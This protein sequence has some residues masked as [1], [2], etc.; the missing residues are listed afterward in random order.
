MHSLVLK[1]I[2][3]SK[4]QSFFQL[5]IFISI[6]IFLV[7]LIFLKISIISS[8]TNVTLDSANPHDFHLQFS[9][10]NEKKVMDIL[11][12][13]G[14]LDS[15][16]ESYTS[17]IQNMTYFSI[18]NSETFAKICNNNQIS[19]FSSFQLSSEFNSL[20]KLIQV[21][22]S[23]VISCYNVK[24]VILPDY[25]LQFDHQFYLSS[26]IEKI[27]NF[28]IFF[29]TIRTN[30]SLVD[31]NKKVELSTER[32]ISFEQ[33]DN[34][35][36]ENSFN[37]DNSTLIISFSKAKDLFKT[38]II[39]NISSHVYKEYKADSSF[40]GY[41][42]YNKTLLQDI[43]DLQIIKNFITSFEE[44][45]VKTLSLTT[46]NLNTIS[47][48]DIELIKALN[49][50]NNFSAI[51]F[52][53]TLPIWL[54]AFFIIFIVQNQNN[55]PLF[56]SFGLLI[57]RGFTKTDFLNLTTLRFV[58]LD[59]V[60]TLLTLMF[61]IPSFAIIS[62]IRLK[63]DEILILLI[64]SFSLNVIIQIISNIYEISNLFPQF[65]DSSSIKI[66]SYK[67]SFTKIIVKL[68]TFT[69][70]IFLILITFLFVETN[71]YL[72]TIFWNIVFVIFPIFIIVCLSLLAL[73]ISKTLLKLPYKNQLAYRFFSK[74]Q[75][76][77]LKSLGF[78]NY[79][80]VMILLLIFSTL[81]FSMLF[82]LNH[83]ISIE[84]STLG[85]SYSISPIRIDDIEIP[86]IK[87]LDKKTVQISFFNLNFKNKNFEGFQIT[88]FFL[89][90]KYLEIFN[91][92]ANNYSNI[93]EI[94]SIDYKEILNKSGNAIISSPLIKKLS[95]N[96][97]Q[98]VN[99]NF[100][101]RNENG[102]SLIT[103]SNV[104]ALKMDFL[105][106]FSSLT[107]NWILTSSFDSFSDTDK[108][109]FTHNLI[110]TFGLTN[111]E[112]IYLEK[113]TNL[114][115]IDRSEIA[116]DLSSYFYNERIFQC[117]FNFIL[118]FLFINYILN[119][120]IIKSNHSRFYEKS[121]NFWQIRGGRLGF[122]K[123]FHF[124]LVF[125]T[126]SNKWLLFQI[127]FFVLMIFINVDIN[128]LRRIQLSSVNFEVIVNSCFLLL[129]MILINIFSTNINRRNNQ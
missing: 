16:L 113:A 104:I 87:D 85:D 2:I 19:S 112:R 23:T 34:L 92:L 97:N 73:L 126:L 31:Y 96:V 66:E 120:L 75:L 76:K 25:I 46:S 127:S 58:I 129:G 111:S 12:N 106:L 124:I 109:D 21:D 53:I 90:S 50:V 37:I 36:S 78:L 79:F 20:S 22:N 15:L 103:L 27:D 42:M 118:F 35:L 68:S 83:Q 71:S 84:R 32:M 116:T 59:F 11:L 49:T 110:I 51:L 47:T 82:D 45:I 70:I 41:L 125:H 28:S 95:L 119:F 108:I 55:K 29:Q 72:K 9:N 56:N 48:F 115:F 62:T 100:N 107:D 105:N 57:K 30:D 33:R 63:I 24:I 114:D 13:I 69:S 74:G 1:T 3:R 88:F 64:L 44:N 40:F 86:K 52:L 67:F 10:S 93:K 18:V 43:N 38:E 14:S 128:Y 101:L 26:S 89:N 91:S 81:I 60:G 54:P 121:S 61:V 6:P 94:T 80:R 5:V 102:S 123:E 122:W 4:K 117:F 7:S 77:F 17:Y 98:K 8:I 99:F 65:I 39:G